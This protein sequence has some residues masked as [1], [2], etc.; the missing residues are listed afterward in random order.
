MTNG[1]RLG[2]LEGTNPLGFLAALGLQV[3]FASE[4]R[5][6]R[7]WWSD[8]I[9]P[10]ALV[11]E[12]FSVD[13]LADQSVIACRAWSSSPALTPVN[14]EGGPLKK[15]EQLK[16]APSDIRVYLQLGLNGGP[17]ATLPAALVAEGSLDKQEIAKPSDLY[18]TAGQQKLLKMAREILEGVTREDLA[19]GLRGPWPY[20]SRLP[21]L[22]WDVADDRVYALRGY[23][24][25][26]S[27]EKK[28]SNPGPEALAIL[29]LSLHPVFAGRERTLTQGCSGSWKNGWYSWPLWHRPAS[30][31]VVRSLLAHA[32]DHSNDPDRE[33]R[34]SWFRSWG[35]GTVLKSPI[36]RSSQGGYG[37]FG[38]SEVVW[39]D[40]RSRIGSAAP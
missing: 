10:H 8:D 33:H 27:G 11:D 23:D 5:W 40:Q 14:P 18:F 2:G 36:R 1:T 21:S 19:V 20:T 37:T 29:G 24:P 4:S 16:L 25:T 22:M 15:G 28:L 13:H 39:R 7:L 35:V 34:H 3:A 26:S 6:P 12:N 17:G 38:P 9:T 31:F 30:P 32:Y